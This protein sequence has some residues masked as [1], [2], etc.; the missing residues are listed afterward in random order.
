MFRT[1]IAFEFCVSK[2]QMNETQ[3][4]IKQGN[5][6]HFLSY[7]LWFKDFVTRVN[8]FPHSMAVCDI[9]AILCK[10][11]GCHKMLEIFGTS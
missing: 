2:Y 3:S 6:N 7:S 8:M 1:G 5:K 11:C 4:F 9:Y 10:L